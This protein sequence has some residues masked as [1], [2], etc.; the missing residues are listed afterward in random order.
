VA[1]VAASDFNDATGR[2]GTDDGNNAQ[3]LNMFMET[4]ARGATSVLMAATTPLRPALLCVALGLL[5]LV[6]GAT[7]EEPA[8]GAQTTASLVP[9][10]VHPSQ[11]SYF[12]TWSAQGYVYGANDELSLTDYI[13]NST[14]IAHAV[15]TAR[16][17]FTAA[18]K[19]PGAGW[20]DFYPKAR[21]DLW[22]LL[23]AG[24]AEDGKTNGSNIWMNATKWPFDIPE[25]NSTSP[26][27]RLRRFNAAVQKLGW[28][29]GA[30]W[31]GALNNFEKSDA[32]FSIEELATWSRD[33]GINYWKVDFCADTYASHRVR[34]RAKLVQSTRI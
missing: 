15:L 23:D 4:A 22:F 6:G 34:S 19:L 3:E 32:P 13:K 24:W 14:S 10:K 30:L 8:A 5:Q 2:D 11:L 28:K 9:V 17:A 31:F 20:A 16:Y 29:G 26:T 27:D 33:A 18:S 7:V 25:R 12:T 1:P 21:S